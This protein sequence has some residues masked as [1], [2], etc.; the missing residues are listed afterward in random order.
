V[1]TK[2]FNFLASFWGVFLLGGLVGGL[3]FGA[4]FG[5][6]L[7][8][9]LSTDWIW[10]GATHDTAQH[11][12]G[13]EFFRADS[14]GGIIDGLAYPEGLSMV[15]MDV[16]PL[17]ALPLKILGGILPADFQYFGLW[18]IGCYV[19]MGGLA[20]VLVRKIILLVA[21]TNDCLLILIIS[22]AGGLLLVIS[23]MV[24]ARTLYHP[25]LAAHW[26]ILLGILLIFEATKFAKWWKFVS[27]WSAM[28]VG[29]VLIHP[30]FLPMVGAMMLIAGLRSVKRATFHDFSR[31]FT[32]VLLPVLLAVLTFWA[33][34]GFSLGSAAEIRDLHEKGFNLLSFVNPGG[35][36]VIPAFPNA[37]SSPETLMWLGLGVCLMIISAAVLWR[38]RYRRSWQAFRARFRFNRWRAASIIVVAFGLLV[39]SIGVRLDI[40][41]LA[42]FQWQPPDKIYELWSAFRA[43]AREA[44]PFY[45]ATILFAIYWFL[46]ATTQITFSARSAELPAKNLASKNSMSSSESSGLADSK[47]G[48]LFRKLIQVAGKNPLSLAAV[49]FCLFAVIQFADI[50]FSPKAS[51]RREGF[52]VART[53]EPEFRPLS[54]GDLLTTQKHLVMLDAS[55]RGDQSGT[56]QISRTALENHLTLNIGFFARIPEKIWQQQAAWRDKV[57]LGQLT[58][59]DLADYLFATTDEKLASQAAANY[60]V[61]KRGKYYF[62]VDF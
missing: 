25:A 30:Y 45:Y 29:A 31:L 39:F 6:S 16:I 53:T 56:Y 21:R 52:V 41:P 1:K 8:N 28:L 35:Y 5:F 54:I 43:A 55:F 49:L 23:P 38:G 59:D 42:V 19:L 4:E 14:S 2:L 17:L 22:V 15:F 18:A 3:F 46:R 10:H 33:I 58:A 57:K 9:P 24:L 11:F 61:E 32:A 27:I 40:G 20:A 50:W 26:L 44:W 7:V 12:I 60:R 62:V 37:S 47:L 34:G 13:W 48:K 36:S 51:S